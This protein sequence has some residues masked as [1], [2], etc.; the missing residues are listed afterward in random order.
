MMASQ[1]YGVRVIVAYDSFSV[2]DVLFPDGMFRSHL[3][4]RGLVERVKPP[5]PRR[6]PRDE[7]SR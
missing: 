2:G 5:A 7:G 3:L 4:D 1:D 6:A